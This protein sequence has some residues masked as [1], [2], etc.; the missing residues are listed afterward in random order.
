MASCIPRTIGLIFIKCFKY[1]IC[2]SL[3]TCTYN[4]SYTVGQICYKSNVEDIQE[5]LSGSFC[6]Y[7]Y[8]P[9]TKFTLH[10]A[11]NGLSHIHH[12]PLVFYIHTA[13]KV[14][15]L[16]RMNAVRNSVYCIMECILSN[17]VAEGITLNLLK[18][19]MTRM[20]YHTVNCW[21][22]FGIIMTQ[23]QGHRSRYADWCR[24]AY[25]L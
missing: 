19:T 16:Q 8:W 4:R 10:K 5:P 23:L 25:I 6:F 22:C 3:H 15:K 7:P 17:L 14:S 9:V 12:K 24:E 1:I 18:L 2:K 21:I 20:R 11:V 13:G